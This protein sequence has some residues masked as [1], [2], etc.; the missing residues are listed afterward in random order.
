MARSK[1][2]YRTLNQ[3]KKIA[4]QYEEID[5]MADTNTIRISAAGKRFLK[6]SQDI[7]VTFDNTPKTLQSKLILRNEHG[8]LIKKRI[9]NKSVVFNMKSN[10]ITFIPMNKNE[11]NS[12][13]SEG[14]SSSSSWSSD[15]DDEGTKSTSRKNSKSSRSSSSTSRTTNNKMLT[16]PKSK[17]SRSSTSKKSRT[18]RSYTPRA[19][20]SS[21]SRKAKSP[22][23]RS[24]KAKI[25]TTRKSNKSKTPRKTQSRKKSR[26]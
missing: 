22:R 11:S 15:E 23:A 19:S 13:L 10:A 1:K 9:S 4:R 24:T 26:K 21:K 6:E 7:R 12:S 14:S 18:S 8:N 17:T 2:N 25:S 16:L 20:I 5:K 3:I